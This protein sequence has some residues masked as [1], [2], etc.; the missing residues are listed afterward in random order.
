MC[1]NKFYNY[2]NELTGYIDGYNMYNR[3]IM[4]DVNDTEGYYLYNENLH[5]INDDLVVY[6][7]YN[8]RWNGMLT[9]NKEICNNIEHMNGNK[10]NLY[11]DYIIIAIIILL[12]Y[13]V[14][15]CV[16]KKN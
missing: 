14:F 16:L 12:I 4:P 13:G 7:K 9:Q 15:C 8:G 5:N 1:E 10:M 3:N 2:S 11:S 6:D